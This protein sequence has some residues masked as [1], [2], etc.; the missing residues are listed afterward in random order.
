MLILL[1]I[2]RKEDKKLFMRFLKDKNVYSTFISKCKNVNVN[3]YLNHI[4]AIYAISHAFL[5]RE[6]YWAYINEEWKAILVDKWDKA[7]NNAFQ[8]L[9]NSVDYTNMFSECP[10][11]KINLKLPERY[12]ER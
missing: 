7:L 9:N 10:T 1:A 6:T 11:I 2:M 12:G 3:E 4:E 5:W 8:S